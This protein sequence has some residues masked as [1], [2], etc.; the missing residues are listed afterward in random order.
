MD[1]FLRAFHEERWG[2]LAS[3]VGFFVTLVGFA[4]TALQIAIAKRASVLVAERVSEVRQKI[5]QQGLAIDLTALMS[6]I[7]EIKALHRIGAWD[8]MPSR[9]TSIRKRLVSV[10][11]NTQ[12]L[13]RSQKTTI[14]GAIGQ[15]RD[16]E[17]IVEAALASK[18]APDDV[19][20][21]NKI[22]S[23]QSDKLSAVLTAVQQQI[24]A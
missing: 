24:G 1:W 14:Q 16:I 8:A 12:S 17:E 13:T 3:V 22:A 21:L 10:K 9:Y 23:A 4:V 11:S 5:S 6:D 20:S 19:A 7:E 18:H 2:D 15:F